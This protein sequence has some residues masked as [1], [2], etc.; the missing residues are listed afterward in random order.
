MEIWVL[1]APTCLGVADS[2]HCLFSGPYQANQVYNLMIR[3]FFVL[4]LVF[5]G[6]LSVVGLVVQGK[7]SFWL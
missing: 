3:T 5:W 7:F 4:G 6:L 1:A 2:L